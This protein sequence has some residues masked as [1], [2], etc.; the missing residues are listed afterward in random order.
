MEKARQHTA[1]GRG[2]S[3]SG[4]GV[5]LAGSAEMRGSCGPWPDVREIRSSTDLQWPSPWAFCRVRAGFLQA[6]TPNEGQ[7]AG[8]LRGIA[9]HNTWRQRCRRASKR[10]RFLASWRLPRLALSKKRKWSSSSL[11]RSWPSP[12]RASS[13]HR[14]GRAGWPARIRACVRSARAPLPDSP[15]GTSRRYPTSNDF[16]AGPFG[17][18]AC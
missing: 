16:R 4:S 1:L 14:S 3:R 10:S 6:L 8:R 5:A 2:V 17:R 15:L 12:Y 13:E 7:Y 18:Q 9:R 11:S